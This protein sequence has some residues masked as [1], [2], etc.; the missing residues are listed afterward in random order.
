MNRKIEINRSVVFADSDIE[1]A[2]G[3]MF[4]VTLEPGAEF[5]PDVRY[6]WKFGTLTE[7]GASELIVPMTL[8]EQ[9]D[10]GTAVNPVKNK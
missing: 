6:D 8:I 7:P 10:H 1:P 2:I 5:V 3:V 4:R 9:N